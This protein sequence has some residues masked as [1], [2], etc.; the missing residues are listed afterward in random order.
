MMSCCQQTQRKIDSLHRMTRAYRRHKLALMKE[1]MCCLGTRRDMRS[2]SVWYHQQ[3]A[4]SCLEEW[5]TVQGS[6]RKSAF[7]MPWRTAS[8]NLHN[9]ALL[10]SESNQQARWV[11]G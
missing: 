1:Q 5:C 2:S 3:V 10:L 8:S 9:A 11:N 4:R 7:S 6:V